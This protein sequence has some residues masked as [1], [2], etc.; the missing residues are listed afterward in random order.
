MDLSEAFDCIPHELLIAG[1]DAY[2]LN[3]NA[4]IFFFSFLKRQ[5]QSVQINNTVFFNYSYLVFRKV[6][7]SA[8]FSLIYS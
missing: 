5:K 6:Q 1:M 4:L 8:R 7:S 3:E 2:G